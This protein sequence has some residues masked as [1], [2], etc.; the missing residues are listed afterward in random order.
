MGNLLSNGHWEDPAKWRPK[1]VRSW[2][3][4]MAIE[5]LVL[6]KDIYHIISN[7]TLDLIMFICPLR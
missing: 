7:F 5:V 1:V 3:W 4:P 2:V 6:R